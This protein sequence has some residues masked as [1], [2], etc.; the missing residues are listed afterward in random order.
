MEP[1]NE[2]KANTAN[3]ILVAVDVFTRKLR[4]TPVATKDPEVVVEGLKR[5]G[6]RGG[7][8]KGALDVDRGGE[9]GGAVLTFLAGL[10]LSLIH[11]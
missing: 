10:N 2:V 3:F 7:V 11:I 6:V 9:W 4:A 1:L 8:P 5:I